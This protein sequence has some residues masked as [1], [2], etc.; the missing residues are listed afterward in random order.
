[1]ALESK[2]R[3]VLGQDVMLDR[4]SNLCRR[5]VIGLLEYCSMNR[6][7]WVAW[8]TMHWKSILNYVPTINLL[9]NKWLVIVFLKDV[10]ASHILN[11]L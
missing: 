9:A 2:R 8:A 10:D 3:Y 1:M 4:V 6:E 7:E 11:Q 5:A